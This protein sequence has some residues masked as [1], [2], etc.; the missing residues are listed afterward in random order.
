MSAA[1][2]RV[3][4]APA[5][6]RVVVAREL[7]PAEVA[8]WSVLQKADPS[9]ASPFFRPEFTMAVAGSREDAR[10]AI[11]EDDEGVA[12]FF[13][14]EAGQDGVGRPMGGLLSD[15]QGMIGRV[16]LQWDAVK[17]VQRCGLRSWRF[18]HLLAEQKA[19]APFHR[20]TMSSPVM[21]LSDGY[22]A[23]VAARQ[24]AGTEQI[25]KALGLRRKLE[26]EAG[27][28]R[29]ET[30]AADPALLQQLMHWK[31]AQYLASGKTDIFALSWVVQVIERMQA[32]RGADFAGM[33]SVLFAG[34][35]PVAA[36]MGLRSQTTWHYWLPAYDPAFARYSPGILLLLGMAEGASDLGLRMIDLGNGS[37]FYK[38]R[39]MNHEIA[40]AEGEVPASPFRAGLMS[41][42]NRAKAWARH[43]PILQPVRQL[44]TLARRKGGEPPS[45]Q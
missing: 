38:S 2:S 33:L 30:Q 15:Y 35:R 6:Q 41:L 42:R 4:G 43:S 28:V 45:S 11:M 12:G 10:V 9:L 14:F 34:D 13:P 39:L 27:V 24:G 37:T 5:R 36:H 21:D 22:A 44:R 40:I 19:F 3:P 20:V 1:P 31:S 26:R 7:T 17:L 18:D 32:T 8:A 16:G 25:K 29:I 23:Y